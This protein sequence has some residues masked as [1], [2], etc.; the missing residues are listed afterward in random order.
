MH[1]I[2]APLPTFMQGAVA[3]AGRLRLGTGM[4]RAASHPPMP[5]DMRPAPGQGASGAGA[6]G[7]FLPP[8]AVA[9]AG[10]VRFGAGMRRG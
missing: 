1:I 7:A 2:H 6:S 9:D 5:A 3:D 4:R 10:R 8:A